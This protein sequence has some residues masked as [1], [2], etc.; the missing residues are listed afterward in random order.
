MIVLF[1]RVDPGFPL[2]AELTVYSAV[3][4]FYELT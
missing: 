3:E 2:E 4:F 1:S